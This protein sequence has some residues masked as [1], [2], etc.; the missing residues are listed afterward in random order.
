VQ[1]PRCFVQRLRELIRVYFCLL[2]SGVVNIGVGYR[3]RYDGQTCCYWIANP[4]E[5]LTDWRIVNIL[6]SPLRFR[7]RLIAI[8]YTMLLMFLLASLRPCPC[9]G[10]CSGPCSRACIPRIGGVGRWRHGIDATHIQAKGAF[11]FMLN[12]NAFQNILGGILKHPIP[13]IWRHDHG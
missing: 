10:P 9:S 13:N 12:H 6:L 2:L 7:V 4:F 8:P 3:R 5:G 1:V 11:Q